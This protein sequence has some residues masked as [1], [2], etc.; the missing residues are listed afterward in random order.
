M[1]AGNIHP[2]LRL[3]PASEN[4]HQRDPSG[5]GSGTNALSYASLPGPGSHIRSESGGNNNNNEYLTTGADLDRETSHSSRR[6][7]GSGSRPLPPHPPS[8]LAPAAAPE[9]S[10]QTSETSIGQ[11]SILRTPNASIT[12]RRRLSGGDAQQTSSDFDPYITQGL[13]R[14][15]VMPLQPNR[16]RGAYSNNNTVYINPHQRSVSNASLPRTPGDPEGQPQRGWSA[17][18]DVDR[19]SLLIEQMPMEVDNAMSG[20]YIATPRDVRAMGGPGMGHWRNLSDDSFATAASDIGS[21][22]LNGGRRGA[23]VRNSFNS[24]LE[25]NSPTLSM[26]ERDPRVQQAFGA[27]YAGRESVSGSSGWD[28]STQASHGPNDALSPPTDPLPPVPNSNPRLFATTN[29]STPNIRTHG[30]THSHSFSSNSIIS[31]P[32]RSLTPNPGTGHT[33]LGSDSSINA[34]SLRTSRS[35]EE[36]L[37]PARN[38]PVRLFPASVRAA[39]YTTGLSPEAGPV[40]TRTPRPNE[41]GNG[42][43]SANNNGNGRVGDNHGGSSTNT[44]GGGGSNGNGGGGGRRGPNGIPL[45]G[46]GPMAGL[47][48]R[49][50]TQVRGGTWE[51]DSS[52]VQSI[53]EQVQQL[54]ETYAPVRG[55]TPNLN[56][57]T[58]RTP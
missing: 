26:L 54:P 12:D 53:L 46:S 2:A 4:K 50:R 16:R 9:L 11:F 5:S 18:D 38:D 29:A 55:G 41:N 44:G 48:E 27:S 22:E 45:S 36:I 3:S 20:V 58:R 39:G 42:N 57:G 34:R 33:R 37:N 10:H 31:T 32:S 47:V 14:P 49:D 13:P 51:T 24:G 15:T 28:A 23:G 25:P 56:S 17:D 35:R 7:S 30:H 21:A 6:R 19:T 8:G 52:G 43:V 40:P 1:S